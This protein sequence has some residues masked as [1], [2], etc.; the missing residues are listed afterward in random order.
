MS[1]ML[2]AVA[3]V[4]MGQFQYLGY[5]Y[6]SQAQERPIAAPSP[7]V[8]N[9]AMNWA[10]VEHVGREWRG[11]TIVGGRAQEMP[12][13]W[14]RP[15][16]ASYGADEYDFRTLPARVGN[17]QVAVS[18]WVEIPNRGSLGRME[19][20]RQQWLRE[21]GYV[22]GTRVFRN[23]VYDRPDAYAKADGPKADET[24]WHIIQIPVRRAPRFEVR[25]EP[26]EGVRLVTLGEPASA[27]VIASERERRVVT[28]PADKSRR[29]AKAD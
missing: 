25:A 16:P 12:L 22:G 19:R 26:A 21:H 27:P 20:A 9:R 7:I 1:G 3:V 29:V 13:A 2:A 8:Y 28:A 4:S 11:R 18:P 14:G 15:G 23:P 10:G 24:R 17:V 6:E 5:A